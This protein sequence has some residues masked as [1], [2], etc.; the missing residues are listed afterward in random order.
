[1]HVGLFTTLNGSTIPATT[2]VVRSAG[3]NVAGR[4][5][6]D[7]AYDSTLTPTYVTNN[8]RTAFADSTNRVFKLAMDER[9]P[10]MF[11]AVGD[12]STDDSVPLQAFFDD[13]FNI[14][15]AKRFSY[16]FEGVF[17]V[18]QKI[19]AAYPN[20]EATRRFRA[21]RIIVLPR[22]GLPP[23]DEVL[24]IVGPRQVWQGELAVQDGQA[25]NT[26]YANRRFDTGIRLTFASQSSFEVIRVDGSKRDALKIDGEQG[27]WSIRSGTPFALSQPFSRNNIGV[28]IGSVYMRGGGSYTGVASYGTTQAI[29]LVETGGDTTSGNEVFGTGAFSNSFWQRSRLT[30]A[31]TAEMRRYDI[32]K[33]RLE[34]V[35]ADYTTITASNS[36]ATLTFASGDP[37]AKG[38]VVGDT[39]YPQSGANAGVAFTILGFSGTSNRTISVY[40]APN[41]ETAHATTKLV[42]QWSYHQ[43]MSIESATKFTVYPWLPARSNTAWHLMH[44]YAVNVVGQDT[45]NIHIDYVST[46]LGGGGLG[47]TGLYGTSVNTLL[48]ESAEIGILH[49]LRA[50][51]NNFGTKIGHVHIEG[52]TVNLLQI[53]G[54]RLI[55]EGG[56]D[57]HF[58]RVQTLFVRSSP[59]DVFEAPR[60]LANVTVDRGGEFLQTNVRGS[61]SGHG[62]FWLGYAELTNHPSHRLATVI[63]DS[64]TVNI[65]FNDDV[66]RLFGEHH[67][68]EI[69]WIGATGAAPTGTLTLSL[70]AA[71]TAKGWSFGGTTG[72]VTSAKPCRLELRFHKPAKKVLVARFDA[73]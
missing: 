44:G 7:Y 1:M 42:T 49:G 68:A 10:E 48:V 51:T 38:L 57:F 52:V 61:Y 66:A 70:S 23:I 71:L 55:I 16:N 72:S 39:I 26:A 58:D 28:R 59:A 31:S 17:A 20:D 3:Y 9:T 4:G 37:V 2:T 65:D 56:S 30:V 64:S 43:I 5:V 8:P 46:L 32:G 15:N 62:Q 33:V 18:S 21:G 40:P 12:G 45:A 73:A 13:A 69:F 19:Y 29:S 54:G 24:L 34:L 50:D 6:A 36:A 63:A 41:N 67:W 14:E 60:G 35:P 47:A 22:G 27:A 11:G 53:G 25:A